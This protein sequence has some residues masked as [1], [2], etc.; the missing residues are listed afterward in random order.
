MKKK[1]LIVIVLAL[2]LTGCS[3]TYNLTISNDKY[4]E[5]VIITGDTNDEVNSFNRTWEISTDKNE[6]NVGTDPSSEEKPTGKVYQF[7]VSNN[8]LTFKNDFTQ[9]EFRNSSAVSKQRT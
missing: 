4:S 8:I 5:E 2:F 6:F 1:L 7:N 3:C 9:D